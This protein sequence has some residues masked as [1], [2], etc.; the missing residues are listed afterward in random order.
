MTNRGVGMKTIVMLVSSLVIPM[1][2]LAAARP[3]DECEA[4]MKA[5]AY[6][7]MWLEKSR[8]ETWRIAFGTNGVGVMQCRMMPLRFTW[9]SDGTGEIRLKD[10]DNPEVP[11]PPSVSIRYDPAHDTMDM[12]LGGEEMPFGFS[13]KLVY[14][15][16]ELLPWMQ[17][18]V[19]YPLPE[20]PKALDP[21]GRFAKLKA[22][23]PKGFRRVDSLLEELDPNRRLEAKSWVKTVDLEYPRVDNS[24][25]LML[26]DG[27]G[28]Y[29]YYGRYEKDPTAVHREMEGERKERSQRPDDPPC[30]IGP[31][32]ARIDELCKELDA[33]KMYYSRKSYDFGTEREYWRQDAIYI[34]ANVDKFETMQR[35]LGKYLSVDSNHSRYILEVPIEKFYSVS[36]DILYKVDWSSGKPVLVKDK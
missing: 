25:G 2:G 6:R 26:S 18:G 10:V 30:Q 5:N 34:S 17:S 33:E 28:Y 20:P 16:E 29:I 3:A 27:I 11:P 1:M 23:R 24:C 14:E 35:F 19:D 31:S 12:E 13:G 8:G 15:Q 36:D 7:G 9:T 32:R 4:I 22:E 21:A